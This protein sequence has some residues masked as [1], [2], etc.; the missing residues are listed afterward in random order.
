MNYRIS[1]LLL[2]AALAVGCGDDKDPAQTTS[3][4]NNTNNTNNSDG[5]MGGSET[6]MPDN[7]TTGNA[8]GTTGT[9]VTT[10]AGTGDST[11]SFIMPKDG[12]PI[13][14]KA[15]DIWAQDCPPGEKCMPYDNTNSGSWNSTKCSPLDANPGGEGDPCVAEGGGVAGLDNCDVGKLCWY[16]DENNAG[17]CI[18]MCKGTAENGMCDDG[19]ICDVSND[20]V[21]IL[22]LTEC[23]PL[24]QS[25]ADGQICFFSP[26]SNTF[27]CDFD[28]SGEMGAYGDPCEYINVCDYG[29]FCANA[30]A[31]PPGLPCEGAGGCCTPYCDVTQPNSCPGMAGGQECVPWY[32][33]GEAPPGQEDVGA[34][35]I[36]A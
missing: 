16:L 23:D 6:G 34:C 11:G 18:D 14:E 33:E 5:T 32:N 25:C 9:P 30:E 36:P 21:L 28:A 20:G 15:C 27:I 3:A 4:T 7:T 31:V 8:S 12:G 26:F 1:S 29:L 35:A 13:G 24:V 22:C 19:Q 2:G 17:T 10:S